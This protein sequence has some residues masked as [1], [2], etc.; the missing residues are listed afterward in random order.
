MFI[1]QESV[2]ENKNKSKNNSKKEGEEGIFGIVVPLLSDLSI[3]QTNKGDK[4]L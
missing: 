3:P 1:L 2:H 4:P